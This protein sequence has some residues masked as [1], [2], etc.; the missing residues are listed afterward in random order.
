VLAWVGSG[1]GLDLGVGLELGLG[2]GLG[3]GAGLGL[4]LGLGGGG[5]GGG[6]LEGMC[7]PLSQP[8][9]RSKELSGY[10]ML[11]ASTSSNLALGM[12]RSVA[13]AVARPVQGEE[14]TH[15]RVSM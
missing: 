6:G 11:R 13:N 1:L 3:L 8:Q 7:S 5:G 4:G 9:T 15:S 2:L 10:D 12:P 14:H